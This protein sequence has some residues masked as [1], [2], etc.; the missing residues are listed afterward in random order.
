MILAFIVGAAAAAAA[1]AAPP[2]APSAVPPLE[3]SRVEQPSAAAAPVATLPVPPPLTPPSLAPPS[4]TPPAVPSLAP[5]P[6]P[7]PVARP[8]AG[9]GKIGPA[10]RAAAAVPPP[11]R[12]VPGGPPRLL[13]VR[14]QH[15]VTV[16]GKL[17][18]AAWRAAPPSSSFTEQYPDEGG[19][20]AEPTEVR[21]LYDAHALY[22]G[23]RCAQRGAPLTARLTR[24]DRVTSA[25]RI[26]VDI[27]SRFDRLTAFHFGVN[28][29]GVL[30]DGIFFDDATFS[31]DW[32]ENWE[33]R[34]ATDA[35][36]W[37]AELR[38]PF[39]I[40]RFDRLPAQRWGIEVER[41][42]EARHEWDHWAYRPRSVA[43][44]VSSFGVLEGITGIE[45]SRPIEL[46]VAGVGR[47]RHRDRAALPAG[48]LAAQDD[49]TGALEL[50][51]KA[52]PTQGTTFDLTLNPDF[53]QVESDQVVLNLS[54]F[55]TFYPEK[56]PFFLE[57][58]DTFATPRTVLYTRRIGAAPGDPTLPTGEQLVDHLDPTRI[59]AAA[60]L[61]GAAAT[62]TNVGLLTALTAENSADVQQADGRRTSRLVS[63]LSLFNAF[64]ARRLWGQGGD[65]GLLATA[66]NRFESPSSGASR[67]TSDAY[68][69][70][71]DGHWHSPSADYLVAGQ[72]VG[73][74]LAAG[75]ERSTPDGLP[76]A[77]GRLGLGATASAA[78]QGGSHWLASTSHAI[79]G[80]RLDYND[81]GYLDRKNDYLGYVD[82]TYRSFE[83]WW[84]TKEHLAT[85]A[86]SHRQTLDGLPLGDNVRML[87]ATTL[88]N[89]WAM[90]AAVYYHS[91]FFDDRETG[92]G[93]ALEHAASKGAEVWV[94]ADSR[95]V[96]SGALWAQYLSIADGEV[97][98]MNATVM[99]RPT[100][101]VELEVDPTVYTTRGEP[102]F[103]VKDAAPAGGES[104]FFGRLQATS[105]GLVVRAT[106]GLLP[107]L[108]LQFYSQLFFANRHYDSFSRFDAPSSR[109][110]VTLDA[111]MPQ[112]LAPAAKPIPDSQQVT[113]NVNLVL[114]W[115]FRL[116][117]VVYL[118]YT[119]A[120]SP[121]V[122]LPA[123]Q[124]PRLDIAPLRNNAGSVDAVMMKISYWWG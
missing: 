83:P 25:D 43:G 75:P 111:L 79:S 73:S 39:R 94:G 36:G 77:P 54:N 107:T 35:D 65:V 112:T 89:F 60:K 22:V 100:P 46:R 91:R 47:Y 55:E 34:V 66:V 124:A 45:P 9:A 29:A 98:Q 110:R 90:N 85:I 53:G 104:Y 11:V 78:K 37:S 106:V 115:E 57:G 101:R 50:D 114:R 19:P 58:V 33:A 5:P 17:D 26:T 74:L 67:Q 27:S 3:A 102:R 24:R 92:D 99:I 84:Q 14:T 41:Y 7:P 6:E 61:V 38:I 82:L 2:P 96:V 123:M 69:G 21:V 10:P 88:S 105:L 51:G 119:R 62:R 42:T 12:P 120:Q 76:I 8:A 16:D 52:H 44:F 40:L 121:P 72:V 97:A 63:P 108:T 15:P 23:V 103:V 20:A 93:T 117:S 68:V 32:D 59:W 86:F 13:A 87:V 95:N 1:A 71:L 28:A 122:D 49:W 4:V 116:G 56:R 109:Q 48:L 81:F 118:V 113:L 70:A 30:D 80:S 18:D 64:R 31:A